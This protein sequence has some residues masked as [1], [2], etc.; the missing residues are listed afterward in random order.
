M[1]RAISEVETG[2]AERLER[3]GF[4]LV[5]LEWAGSDRR[6]IL[7]VRMDVSEEAAREGRA[8]T[9]ADCAA[10]SRAL[11]P[12]LN[13]LG[14]VPEHYVLEVSSPGVDRP[15]TRPRDWV[16]FAGEQVAV[17]GAGTLAGRATRLEGELMGIER[18]EQEREWVVLRLASGDEVQVPRAEILRAHLVHSW[19]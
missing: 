15:L 8:V 2:L 14:S 9:V 4:E 1:A 5:E 7:R 12:W 16:R 18:D 11:E 17:R 13:G 6:P 19:K 3:Y 10:V